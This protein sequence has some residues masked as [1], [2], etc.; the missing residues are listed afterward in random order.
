VVNWSRSSSDDVTRPFCSGWGRAAGTGTKYAG[1]LAYCFA[2]LYQE[3]KDPFWK[4]KAEALVQGLMAAQEPRTGFI[5]STGQRKAGSS[6]R[7]AS[8]DLAIAAEA[9]EAV[10]RLL[11][12]PAGANSQGRSP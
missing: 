2:R 7:R 3:T 10:P 11:T 6:D 4:A 9:V 12:E 1:R 8:Y 5:T